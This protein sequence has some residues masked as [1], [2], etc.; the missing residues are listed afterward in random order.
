[1]CFGRL[2]ICQQPWPAGGGGIEA[3]ETIAGHSRPSPSKIINLVTSPLGDRTQR[4]RR[5]GVSGPST[6]SV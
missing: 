3:P 5:V 2:V 1:M 4:N 6:C